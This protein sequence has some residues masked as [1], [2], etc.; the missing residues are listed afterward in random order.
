MPSHWINTVAWLMKVSLSVKLST[1]CTIGEGVGFSIQR[2]QRAALRVATQRNTSVALARPGPTEELKRLPSNRAWMR[3]ACVLLS[4]VRF[5]LSVC[6]AGCC[7]GCCPDCCPGCC[8][9][10][11]ACYMCNA[12][13]LYG[14][15]RNTYKRCQ[16]ACRQIYARLAARVLR[17]LS[18]TQCV[19]G[20]GVLPTQI[21]RISA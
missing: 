18:H 3:G 8:L 11:R 9:G 19:R 17:M 10:C 16:Q 7:P 6:C 2:G 14:P 20:G 4:P 13:A 1:R 5:M 12:L 15:Q 21:Y